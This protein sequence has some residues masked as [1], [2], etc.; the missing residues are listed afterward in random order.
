MGSGGIRPGSGRKKGRTSV[1]P[2]DKAVVKNVS[3]RPDEWEALDA[4]A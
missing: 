3:L 4:V 1:A 2:E